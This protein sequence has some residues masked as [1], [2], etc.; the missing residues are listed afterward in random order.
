MHGHPQEANSGNRPTPLATELGCYQSP[1]EVTME[2]HAAM[3]SPV[4]EPLDREVDVL[5]RAI[6]LIR[7]RLPPSWSRAASEEVVIG[8]RHV[9]ALVEVT[10]PDGRRAFLIAEARRVLVTRDLTDMVEQLR[11]VARGDDRPLCPLVIARY[12]SPSAQAWLTERDVS[13]ADATGNM[14]ITL[15]KPGLYLRDTG[16]VRDLWRGPGRPRGTLHG[17]PAAR[18]VRALIDF[19]PPM[20]MSDLIH[21]SGASTGA[22][23]RVV[24]FLEQEAL[25]D[26]IPRG[27][28]TNVAWRPL[29]ERWSRDYSFQGSN[30]I[31]KYLQPRG[32]TSLLDDL[33]T[34]TGMRYAVSGSLA[35]HQWAPYAPVRLAMIYV[36][37]PKQFTELAGLRQVDTGANVLLAAGKYDVVFDRTKNFDGVMLAAPSQT[38]VDLLNGPGRSPAEAQALLDWMESNENQW[39]R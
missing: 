23:Y 4:D 17:P 7:E 35:A 15:D 5:R 13:Y 19:R 11:S 33:R 9:D 26:R 14:R 37:N 36:D 16:A 8:G 6:A 21:V 27:P 1:G 2:D 39:R 3:S 28:I 20:S 29:L 12:I 25:I 22:T 32:V 34:V 24:E 30:S 10:S 31:S 38:A 18:V